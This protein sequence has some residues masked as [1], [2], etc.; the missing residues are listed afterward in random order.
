VFRVALVAR[1]RAPRLVDV[2]LVGMPL[3]VFSRALPFQLRRVVRMRCSFVGGFFPALPGWND[4][5]ALQPVELETPCASPRRWGK[6][7]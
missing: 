3:C 4:W 5:P 1:A 7:S 6:A 2:V